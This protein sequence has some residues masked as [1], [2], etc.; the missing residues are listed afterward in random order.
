MANLTFDS[1]RIRVAMFFKYLVFEKFISN[2]KKY[3]LWVW[4]TGRVSLVPVFW[5]GREDENNMQGE[6]ISS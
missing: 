2:T 3:M 4:G 6:E 1:I 5:S